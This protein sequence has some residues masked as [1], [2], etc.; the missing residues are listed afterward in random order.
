MSLSGLATLAA[1][2]LAA[3]SAPPPPNPDPP[4]RRLW[5]VTSPGGERFSASCTPP[6][7]LLELSG[8]YPGAI[9]EPEDEPEPDSDEEALAPWLADTGTPEP[10]VQVLTAAP[11]TEP[12]AITP[13]ASCRNCRHFEPDPFNPKGGMGHCEIDAPAS[14]KPGALW[15]T[16]A[17][18]CPDFTI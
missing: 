15:P 14:L 3:A 7:T 16:G 18:E 5:L 13:G 17:V 1:A 12:E 4:A 2:T 8:W 9:I 11:G 10:R 6:A